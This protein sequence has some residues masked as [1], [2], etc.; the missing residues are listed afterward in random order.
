VLGGGLWLD[1]LGGFV[2]VCASEVPGG[3]VGF[4]GQ[5]KSNVLKT[6]ML[7]KKVQHCGGG[8]P[9]SLF[10]VAECCIG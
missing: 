7:G 2:R 5:T 3:G 4:F 1:G 9:F 8:T 10:L 6:N